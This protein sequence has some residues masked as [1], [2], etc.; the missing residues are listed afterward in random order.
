MWYVQIVEAFR[1]NRPFNLATIFW[2]TTLI[3]KRQNDLS[4][5]GVDIQS[6]IGPFT[7]QASAL[8]CA[9]AYNED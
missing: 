3:N 7:E 4:L 1:Y 8:E 9:D 5:S 6:I 2:A